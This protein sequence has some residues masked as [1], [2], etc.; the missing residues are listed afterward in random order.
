MSDKFGLMALTT[1]ESQYL[2]GQSSL[3]C[4]QSTAAEADV[5][6]RDLLQSCYTAACQMLRD[7]R[8]S[9]DEIA[10]FLLTKET[11]T[12]DEFMAFLKKPEELPEADLE[13]EPVSETT[14]T[15]ETPN[16]AETPEA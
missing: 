6:V 1:T 2:G 8:E 11:I 4:A 7:N 5:E 12:G 14:E 9:L 10:L 3:N 16:A 13:A 15:T